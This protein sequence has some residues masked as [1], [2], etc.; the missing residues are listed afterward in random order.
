VLRPGATFFS[1][2]IVHG[3]NRDLYEF[4]M[5]PQ[6]VDPV[7]AEQHARDGAATAG[8]DLLQWRQESPVLEFFDIATVIVFLRKV[9]WTVP[10]F[11]VEKYRDRL[12]AMHELIQREGKFVSR[13]QRG[14]VEA[15]KPSAS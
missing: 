8:L 9:I 3:T 10:D 1:Q 14:L 5:G 7:S 2:Q 13:G 12:V 4:M 6:W 15:R 11:S